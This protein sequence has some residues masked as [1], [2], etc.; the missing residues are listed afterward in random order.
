MW[1]QM[2]AGRGFEDD[3]KLRL[4]GGL[5]RL[6]IRVVTTAAL[7]EW[8]LDSRSHTLM[9]RLKGE[10]VQVVNMT[11]Y[12]VNMMLV[13]SGITCLLHRLFMSSE[14]IKHLAARNT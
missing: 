7:F 13:P 6:A 14:Y 8:Y 10:R 5:G 2:T 3:E 1:I 12:D 11:L 4:Q 9:G